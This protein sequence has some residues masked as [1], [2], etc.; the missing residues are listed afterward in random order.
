MELA[1]FGRGLPFF[2]RQS[3]RDYRLI[4]IGASFIEV[5]TIITTAVAI[6]ALMPMSMDDIW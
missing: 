4:S 3:C 2:G 5:V 1:S 6:L